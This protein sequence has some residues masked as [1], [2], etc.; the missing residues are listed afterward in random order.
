MVE[1]FL[2]VK[3]ARQNNLKNINLKL[4]HDKLI[5]IT[6]VSGSGKSSL[7]FDTIFAE[8]QWR[9]IE[10]LSTYARLFLEKLD[11]PDVDSIQNIR[12]AIAL[13]QKNPVRSSRSTV[14][15]LSEIHDYI[16]L[17]YAKIAV[18]YCPSCGSEVKEWNPTQIF[19]E[20][21]TNYKS[22]K[23]LIVFESNA[24]LEDIKKKG[25]YRIWLDGEIFEVD[26]LIR[27]GSDNALL[28]PATLNIV[29]DRL[30]IKDEP[31]LSDS[32]ELAWKEGNSSL[33][34]VIVEGSDREPYE[35]VSFCSGEVCSNCGTIIQKPTPLLFSFNH[36][37]G[38]CPVCKGFGDVLHYDEELIVPDKELSI[39]EGAIDPWNKPAY[40]WWK[41]QFLRHA[42]KDNVDIY[43][44]YKMLNS[45]EK[46][47]IYK[48]GNGFY[49][50]NDFFEELE[51]KRYKIHVRVFLSRYR[52]AVTC[53]SCNGKRLR[54]E[55]L[56]FKIAGIDIAE[57]CSMPISDL[58]SFFDG[59]RLEDFQMEL[60]KEIIRQIKLRLS[61]L[62]RLGLGYLS[63]NRNVKTLS[64]GEYQRVNIANQIGAFLK[65]TLYV[66]DEPTI[67][68]HA[69]DT[70]LISEIMAELSKVG[71]TVIVVEHDRQVISSADW[72]VELGPGGGKYGGRIVFSG[73]KEEFLKTDTLTSRFIR[74]VEKIDFPMKGINIKRVMN[75]EFIILKGASGNN[76]KSVDLRIPVNTLT[77]ITGVSGSGKSSLIIETL[78]KVL[79][80]YFRIENELPLPYKELRGAD[81][82]KGVKL[83]SQEPIGK[84]PR[85]NP[86]TYLK[87]FEH[88]RR[89]FSEQLEARV[90]DYNAGFFSFNVPGGR[91]ESC[92]GAGYQKLEMY[93]FEDLYVKC[94][95]CNGKRFKPEALR[96][97]Y[98]GKNIFDVLEMTV[99]EAI[100]F[101]CD[102]ERVRE[103]LMIMKEIGLGYLKLGQPAPTLSGGESQRLK[104]CAEIIDM[105]LF[106]G[107]SRSYKPRKGFLYILDEPT[108]GLHF[109]DVKALIGILRRLVDL[110][111]TVVVIE[112]NL[113]LIRASDWIIDMGPEGG[114]RGGNIIFEGTPDDMVFVEGSYTARY[115]KE[116][117]ESLHFG[118]ATC[119]S[120]VQG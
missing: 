58:I 28:E 69:R 90:H 108:I 114:D 37:L 27:R 48:G 106:K 65:G 1:R 104:I 22:K 105:P 98:K 29:V 75:N 14:G 24:S 117:M 116:Y 86:V 81:L 109:K 32:I 91:C 72:I 31:R 85:S 99:D 60:S 52:R 94:E 82:I 70:K 38:A 53:P 83:I 4:P 12:P 100:D 25:F 40:K 5:A 23:A 57:L 92:K 89:L 3:G 67:G 64:G 110:N 68:L 45:S 35:L 26:E 49:G 34:I 13:E 50:I 51:N 62:N 101:F 15:T 20:L 19:N 18:Q 43:K 6:G 102:V 79:A 66:L 10:S 93:F 39:Y 55:A 120:E 103:N 112:H 30:V 71:N 84:T 54:K 115:L 78:Y 47:K 8:G 77:T 11:R 76:L 21:I 113:D 42:P 97:T 44:P 95:D 41:E 9:F 96:I 36:P 73:P 80:R 2:I 74:N 46:E 119:T 63:L 59:I 17:L 33:K 61:F 56:S 111:N 87:I 107:F 118:S 16:R 7:A 88:V